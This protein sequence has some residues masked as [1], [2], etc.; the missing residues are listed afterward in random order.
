MFFDANDLQMAVIFVSHRWH[1]PSHPDPEGEQLS[2]VKI[3]LPWVK[4]WCDPTDSGQAREAFFNCSREIRQVQGKTS[5]RPHW[6]TFQAAYFLGSYSPFDGK[7]A[8]SRGDLLSLGGDALNRIG[9]WYDYTSTPQAPANRGQLVVAL[10][11]IHELLGACNLI[12]LRHPGD[13]YDARAWCAAEVAIDPDIDRTRFR[14]ICVR[15]DKIGEAFPPRYCWINNYQ[16]GLGLPN[17][18][19]INYA[20]AVWGRCGPHNI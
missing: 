16:N 8:G 15:L 1:S 14:Q 5:S 19:S 2:A 4:K 17:S 6:L 12:T 3:F 7:G 13:D 20:R 18:Q 11:R 9:V 10:E